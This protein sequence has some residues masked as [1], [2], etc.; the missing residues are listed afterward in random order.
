MDYKR[1]NDIHV[2]K[3]TIVVNPDDQF[4]YSIESQSQ[5]IRVPKNYSESKEFIELVTGKTGIEMEY[6]KKNIFKWLKRF[7][8]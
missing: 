6:D 1:W 5:I 4:V 3:Q 2:G 8:S 7:F